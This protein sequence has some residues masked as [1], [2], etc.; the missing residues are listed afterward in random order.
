MPRIEELSR[1]IWEDTDFR[2]KWLIGGLLSTI[3]LLNII[4]LGYF[5][6]YARQ[7]RQGGDLTLPAWDNWEELLMDCL[8]MFILKLV[9]L[10]IPFLISLGISWM[11]QSVLGIFSGLTFIPVGWLFL[12]LGIAAGLIFWMA[13]LM[14][15]L[16]GQDWARVFDFAAVWRV[17]KRL[18]P[19]LAVPVLIFIG[20]VTVGA[21]LAGF[22]FFL[23]FGPFVAFS[24][25][26]YLDGTR[27]A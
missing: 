22:A 19:K 3:P 5:L 20:L 12:P 26:A 4:V 9:F 13:A 7:L 2:S 10:G 18:A 1:R 6:R 16:P 27:A 8:R 15:Y 21:P 11:L 24:T 25:A 23:G 14:R 17:S